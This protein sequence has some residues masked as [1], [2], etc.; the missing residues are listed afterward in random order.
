MNKNKKRELFSS[1]FGFILSC[2]G[3]AIGLGN[4]WMFPYKLGENG[5]A[6][7]LIPYFI[8]VILLGTVGLIGEFALGR[9]FKIGSMSS[10]NSVLKEKN[11]KGSSIISVIPTLG[12]TGIFMFYTV[13]IGWVL[14]YFFISLT[15]EISTI[16]TASYFS[17]FTTSNGSV[18]WHGLAVLITLLIVSVGV[19]KGIEKINKIII[20]LLFVIFILLIFKSLSLPNS[21]EGVK[22]LLKPDWSYLLKP[23]TWVMAMGQAFFTV[24]LTGCCMVLYGSY[25]DKKFD[26]PNS[27]INTALFDTLSAI[28]AAFVI[29]PAVFALGFNPTAGPALL[30]VTVPSIFQTMKLGPLLSALF[31]LS[32]IFASI[33]SSIAML[34]GPVEAIMNVTKWNRKKTTYITAITAFILAI[35]LGLSSSLFDNFTNFITLILSPLGALISAIVFFYVLDPIKTLNNLNEGAKHKLGMWFMKFGKYIFVPTTVIVIILGL[36]YGGI[37]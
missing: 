34:E 14:K 17:T 33:S 19:S 37:G 13:V 23:K 8:F 2:I 27:A 22:Y 21:M 9:Q 36:V 4:I 15:G 10:I 6:A 7:F 31:F 24:S 11:I 18:F 20:P 29:M 28:L 26:I 12:L 32:I 3:A 30:F 35:P 16:D 1:K 5:G 25:T